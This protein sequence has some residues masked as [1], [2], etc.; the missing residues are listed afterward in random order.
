MRIL[1]DHYG[2]S[3]S[4]LLLTI[5]AAAVTASAQSPVVVRPGAPGQ[6]TKQ[7]PAD[8]RPTLPPT[9][10][11]DVEFMQGMIM[12]HTQ[13]VEMTDMI[14]ERTDNRDI[15]FLGERISKSQS[16]EMAFMVRWLEARGQ[17]TQMTS[18]GGQHTS[19][20]HGAPQAPSHKMPGMLSPKQMEELKAAKGADFDLLF[21]KGMIQHHEGALVMVKD[22]HNSPGTAQD[23][24]LFNFAS[25]VD[26]GQRAEIKT[27]QKLL[28][29]FHVEKKP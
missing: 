11:K 2:L 10:M 27:M 28:G 19:H 9:S 22:L 4:A 14:A 15:Q 3:V 24:E 16:D 5:F 7:L 26:S 1:I 25:D 29:K 23:A 20:A 6:A 13:A 12:H 21:L 18:G 17:A 8:T